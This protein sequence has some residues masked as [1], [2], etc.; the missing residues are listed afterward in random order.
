MKIDWLRDVE[1]KR[2]SEL[3]DGYEFTDEEKLALLNLIIKR[4]K[5]RKYGKYIQFRHPSGGTDWS[6]IEKLFGIK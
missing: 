1:D 4:G 3:L 2:K 6:V 5:P